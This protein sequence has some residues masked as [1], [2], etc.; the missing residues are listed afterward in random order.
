MIIS[1][2]LYTIQTMYIR[3]FIDRNMLNSI[4]SS[5]LLSSDFIHTARFLHLS[6]VTQASKLQNQKRGLLMLFRLCIVLL[7]VK[8]YYSLDV[9]ILHRN[10]HTVQIIYNKTFITNVINIPCQVMYYLSQ[11]R[12]S[13]LHWMAHRGYF[14]ASEPFFCC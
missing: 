2:L 8:N 5:K 10:S 11:N 14:P 6:N 7:P 1:G 3:Y 12:C 4:Y 13:P 9:A